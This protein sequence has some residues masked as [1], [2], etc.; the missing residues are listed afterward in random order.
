[1][2]YRFALLLVLLFTA[3]RASAQSKPPS[4]WYFPT[5][6][7]WE[8]VSHEVAGA[9][10]EQL[11]RA[12]QYAGEKNSKGVVVLWR[13]RLLAERYWDGCTQT[14]RH[15]AYSASKSLVSTLVGMAIEEKKIAG[16]GQSAA[17]FLREWQGKPKYEAITIGHM[18]SMTSGLEGGKR[19]FLR[20]ALSRDER[21]FA[22]SL[23][24]QFTPGTHWEYQNS[25][26]RLFFSLLPAATGESLP[27]YTT[28]KLLDPLDMKHTQWQTKRL[29]RDQYT[30]L[31]TTPRDAARFGLLILAG[32][33]WNGQQ[34]IN[35]KWLQRATTAANPRV[36]P[37]YGYLWWLNGG[38]RHYLPL[39]PVARRGPIFPGCPADAFA[40]LG[41]DDQKIYV[42]P[43]LQIVVTRFGDAADS[44]SPAISQFDAKFLGKICDSF[45]SVSR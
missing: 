22:T 4:L 23:P 13:G 43:S 24:L 9:D 39:H 21:A 20:G 3:H 44:T 19:N 11:E 38:D 10:R 31:S 12:L 36:N 28:R 6:N 40:A 8:T 1:M 17:V 2:T 14:T 18:L 15:P 35:R 45:K 5:A 27:K 7:Q 32:G 16:T 34:L 41:K 30:F 26:Y 37:S 25:A 29:S 42:V 33:N